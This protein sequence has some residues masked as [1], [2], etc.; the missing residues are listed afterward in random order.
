MRSP[1]ST[2]FCGHMHDAAR[3]NRM[4]EYLPE[5]SESSHRQDVQSLTLKTFRMGRTLDVTFFGLDVT[6]QFVQQNV[7]VVTF[8]P[9]KQHRISAEGCKTRSLDMTFFALQKVFLI[10]ILVSRRR[11]VVPQGSCWAQR[12]TRVL[13]L[14]V[15]VFGQRLLLALL[16]WVFVLDQKFLVGILFRG[17]RPFVFLD[18]SCCA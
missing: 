9:L 12:F 18:G 1:N 11:F 8:S 2:F 17:F 7:L 13:L 4:V 6:F 5:R 3:L 15:F 16:L 10:K 14:R